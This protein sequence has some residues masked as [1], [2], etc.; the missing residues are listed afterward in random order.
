M[1]TAPV[2]SNGQAC[3]QAIK[4]A[5]SKT[6]Y[7]YLWQHALSRKN[8][9]TYRF[10]ANSLPSFTTSRIKSHK[11]A[12]L[13]ISFTD[14]ICGSVPH[15]SPILPEETSI[16]LEYVQHSFAKSTFLRNLKSLVQGGSCSG[17][18]FIL[19]FEYLVKATNSRTVSRAISRSFNC[20]FSW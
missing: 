12:I 14:S 11:K 7:S 18:S 19:I 16:I 1:A 2:R 6:C 10:L 9:N 13:Y 4:P 20:S 17:S 8:V 3:W 15:G 5:A